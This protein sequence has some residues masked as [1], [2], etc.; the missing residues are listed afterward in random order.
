M[1]GQ[2]DK[3]GVT[4]KEAIMKRTTVKLIHD[5][6][7]QA[8]KDINFILFNMIYQ[9]VYQPSHRVG[10]DEKGRGL[11]SSRVAGKAVTTLIT[12]N[13]SPP[14]RTRTF[15]VA[16]TYFFVVLRLLLTLPVIPSL[17]GTC[18]SWWRPL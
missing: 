13:Y 16:L 12:E 10:V 7:I 6:K 2:E 5:A 11:T 1:Y 3:D 8:R 15:V 14:P 17:T 4:P 18:T 9:Y